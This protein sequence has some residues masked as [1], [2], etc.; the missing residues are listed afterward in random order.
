M[1][2]H[3]KILR[4]VLVKPAGPDCNL[5]CEYCFYLKKAGLFNGKLHRMS[6]ET[7]E[8]LIRQLLEQSSDELSVTWQG[9]EP[10]LMGLDFYRNAIDFYKKYGK[11]KSVS[12]SFQTN[13]LL[14]NQEWANFFKEFNFLVGLSIDEPKHI[15]D[16]YRKRK[17]G[18]GS[19]V[20]VMETANML[21]EQGVEV[22]A[23][24]C[25]TDYSSN[26][27]SEI[28]D[29][30]KKSGFT[31]MQFIPILEPDK[32]DPSKAAPF[33]VSAN[34]YGKF[35]NE[36]FDLWVKDYQKGINPTSVR[37]I[38]STFYRYVGIESPECTLQKECGIYLVIEHNGDV[39]ACDFFVDP[40]WKLGNIHEDKLIDMLNSNKMFEFGK[41]KSEIPEKCNTCKWLNYC[42]GGCP[43]DRMNDLRDKGKNHFCESYQV[44]LEHA[45]PILKNM[46][47]VWKQQQQQ[48]AFTY[49]ANNHFRTN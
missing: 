14:L 17:K 33:S 34:A 49:N 16:H 32:A 40:K 2:I 18:K 47:K 27:A 23:L 13:G 10:S 24:S 5:N 42:F 6:S 36:I 1:G 30:L 44:F 19:W 48:Q 7:Q 11:G 45:D 3:R 12:N 35:L 4:S 15:Q 25:I 31:W 29:F 21:F 20:K 37:H 43:K 38:E 46:A 9:G 39:F 8:E 26:H 22:N 28:F 41:I